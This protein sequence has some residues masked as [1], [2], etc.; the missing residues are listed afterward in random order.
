MLF[1]S[2]VKSAL[3][4]NLL[5]VFIILFSF[6]SQLFASEM[7]DEMK[8]KMIGVIAF[9]TGQ[10]NISR[11]QAQFMPASL[12]EEIFLEDRIQTSA[13]SRLQILLRDET[14][15]TLGPNAE[16]IVDKFI[17]DPDS[18][19]VEVSIKSGAFRFI[20]GATASSG[21][22]AVKLKLP[23]ATLSIRGT[24]VLG[25]VSPA[26]TQI[27]LM[28]GII[29]VITDND[30]KEIS[31]HGWGVEVNDQGDISDPSPVETNALEDVII[32]LE[33]TEEDSD[34]E[35]D[36]EDQLVTN[37]QSSS[38]EDSEEETQEEV[39]S[40]NTE[41]TTASNETNDETNAAGDETPAA[42]NDSTATTQSSETS[43]ETSSEA[44]S[45]TSLAAGTDT[46]S[47]LPST[48]STE[49]SLDVNGNLDG[50][51][52]LKSDS[53]QTSDFDK[54]IL[55]SFQQDNTTTSSS[56]ELDTDLTVENNIQTDDETLE[57]TADGQIK[58]PS[59][60]ATGSPDSD[61]TT[62]TAQADIVDQLV[63]PVAIETD[64]EK[65]ATE[66]T[67]EEDMKIVG[68]EVTSSTTGNSATDNSVTDN[69]ATDNSATDNSGAGNSGTTPINEAPIAETLDD[70]TLTDTSGDDDFANILSK[71]DANDPD[72]DELAFAIVNGST[73][74]RQAGY[75]TALVGTY[76][77]LY[78]NTN[79]G[80]LLYVPDD[81]AIE[82]LTADAT[83]EFNLNISDGTNEISQILKAVITGADDSLT[84]S[85]AAS[86]IADTTSLAVGGVTD[87][88][89]TLSASDLDADALE[90][91]IIVDGSVVT[92]ASSPEALFGP[93][94][95]PGEPNYEFITNVYANYDK[96]Y[97]L[98]DSVYDTDIVLNSETGA[99]KI[100]PNGVLLDALDDGET[101]NEQ[102]NFQVTNGAETLTRTL[103]LNYVGAEDPP[104]ISSMDGNP[105]SLTSSQIDVAVARVEDRD[106]ETFEDQ[107]E[108]LPAWIGF[109]QDPANPGIYLWSIND[110]A[111]NDPIVDHYLNGSIQINFQAKSGNQASDVLAQTLTFACQTAKCSNFIQS[112]DATTPVPTDSLLVNLL[113][114]TGG[115]IFINSV[116]YNSL[117]FLEMQNFFDVS[118]VG[119]FHRKYTVSSTGAYDGDWSVGH[120]VMANYG[121]QF[122]QSDVYLTFSDLQY[123]NN[124]GG[125]FTDIAAFD[126]NT[127]RLNNDGT[128]TKTKFAIDTGVDSSVGN[129]FDVDVTHHVSFLKNSA[130]QYALAGAIEITPSGMNEAGYEDD[131]IVLMNPRVV[132]LEPQ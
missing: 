88:D 61:T 60:D 15:F 16:L 109:A 70:L 74:T 92:Q 1:R 34:G 103:D 80:D 30:I 75:D 35:D 40:E 66:K 106:I 112:T 62:T 111:G 6:T 26:N 14:T 87:I 2:P 44:S 104:E 65:Q 125:S 63:S 31:Q 64:T 50:D 12:G 97:D 5:I 128:F 99:F 126:W 116:E 129:D 76:G 46:D 85:N 98:G 73:N 37:T 119:S 131:S 91:S 38:D 4:G 11:D 24:E 18:S 43:S 96:A 25:D 122:V 69:S 21:P 47:Q 110:N 29:N 90:F 13:D 23:K 45:D 42:Q 54:I 93:A 83:E 59:V 51:G 100:L 53:Y 102:V 77:T 20:S 68:E 17:Y 121:T 105:M 114:N 22:D 120:V 8:G 113:D 52:Q 10:V 107:T 124:A 117:T 56:A 7:T 39:D 101:A 130:S 57:L 41:T 71:I 58:Q 32:L 81:T 9:K 36:S 123:S 89:G 127:D 48:T 67:S 27:I 3:A 118:S 79:N 55:A 33:S 108:N 94:P 95:A 132:I 78:L 49:T 19:D 84:S 72:G 28:S 82:G 86:S 115:K